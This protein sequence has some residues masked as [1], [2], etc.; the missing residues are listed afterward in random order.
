VEG[1]RCKILSNTID[2]MSSFGF[3]IYGHETDIA[4]NMVTNCYRSVFSQPDTNPSTPKSKL[5]V[6]R[7]HYHHNAFVNPGRYRGGNPGSPISLGYGFYP[8]FG[9]DDEAGAI[10]EWNYFD[11]RA[12][13]EVISVKSDFNVLRFNWI[14]NGQATHFSIRMG[15]DNLIYGNIIRE[16]DIGWRISGE[17][18]FFAFNVVVARNER[19][20]MM[21]LHVETPEIS[22]ESRYLLYR[23]ASFNTQ[24]YNLFIGFGSHA[25]VVLL[26]SSNIASLPIGNLTASNIIC[27]M[28]EDAAFTDMDPFLEASYLGQN[29]YRDNFSLETLKPIGP[30]QLRDLLS[31]FAMHELAIANKTHGL[32]VVSLQDIPWLKAMLRKINQR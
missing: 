9:V 5:T 16:V 22:P 1:D 26:P 10:V 21:H 31:F 13:D 29:Q 28:Y 11:T 17:R 24:I 2:S 3:G 18:N 14:E 19:A 23:T 4:D 15:S 32:I 8:L 7:N 6:K 25:K 12:D 30:S 27:T 20:I